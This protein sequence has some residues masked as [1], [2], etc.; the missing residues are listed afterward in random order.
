MLQTML[1]SNCKLHPGAGSF[2]APAYVRK[3]CNSHKIKYI[4][5]QVSIAGP[6][7]YSKAVGTSELPSRVNR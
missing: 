4:E 6:V 7:L 1:K 3:P 5:G 2:A